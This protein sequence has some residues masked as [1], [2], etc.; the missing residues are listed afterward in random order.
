MAGELL[1]QVRRFFGV[2]GVV[3]WPLMVV[4][5][6]LWYFVGLR[7]FHLRRGLR[8]D[9]AEEFRRVIASKGAMDKGVSS[10][11]LGRALAELASRLQHSGWLVLGEVEEVLRR[12]RLETVLHARAI[13]TLVALAPL[14]GL[15][16]TVHGMIETFRA[17]QDMALFAESGGISGGI[18]EALVTT[19]MGLGLAIPGLILARALDR[20]AA[21]LRRDLDEVEA[22]AQVF[23]RAG[24]RDGR[25]GAGTGGAR[26]QEPCGGCHE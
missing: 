15:L 17:L 26:L 8:G 22:A 16:G 11:V 24:H 10:G 20:R 6:L 19:Q 13:K 1:A 25:K 4:G 23:L 18:S 7:V 3:M 12:R 14:L 5:V 2:G 9:A 21:T